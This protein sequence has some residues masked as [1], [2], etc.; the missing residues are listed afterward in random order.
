MYY[1]PQAIAQGSTWNPDLIC[2]M[3]EAEAAE[4]EAMETPEPELDEYGIAIEDN[5]QQ[6]ISRARC[7]RG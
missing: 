3:T 7:R 5:D 1:I 4:A 2:Q 6:A